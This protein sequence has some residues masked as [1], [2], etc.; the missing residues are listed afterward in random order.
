MA[1]NVLIMLIIL[2]LE[3]VSSVKYKIV[4]HHNPDLGVFPCKIETNKG[5]KLWKDYLLLIVNVLSKD[6]SYVVMYFKKIHKF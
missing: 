6:F 3:P 1:E 5:G 2:G 4:L